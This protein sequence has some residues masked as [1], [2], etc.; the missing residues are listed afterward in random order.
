MSKITKIR[1]RICYLLRAPPSI[2]RCLMFP[3]GKREVE[4]LLAKFQE[5]SEENKKMFLSK[6]VDYIHKFL[7]ITYPGSRQLPS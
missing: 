3:K 5:L 1:K 6:I 2:G 4:G 7:A